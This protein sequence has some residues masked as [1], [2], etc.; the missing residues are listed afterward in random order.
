MLQI[1]STELAELLLSGSFGLEKESLRIDG[2]GFLSHTPHP[3]AGNPNIVRDFCENQTEINTSV[4]PSAHAAVSEL[5]RH[6]RTIQRTL[7]ELTPGEYLWPFSNPPYI[8]NEQDIP[9]AQFAGAQSDK[10]TYRNYLS[11]RYGRYKMTL[12]GIHVNYS[13]HEEL[14]RRDFQRSGQSSYIDYQNNLYLTLAKRVAAYGW[15]LTAVT[16]ASPLLDSSY[17]EK[18]QFDG[19]VFQGLASV[20]CSELG[21]WNAFAPVFDYSS[22][23]AYVESIR[24]YVRR[25][26]LRAPS[27]LYYPVRLKPAGPY[28][29]DALEAGGVN[30]IE[31]RMFDLNPLT[32]VGIDERDVSFAQLLLCWLAATPDQP[33]NDRD[34]VQAVQN[35]KN[36]AHYDLKTVNLMLPDGR[37]YSVAHAARN[38]ITLMREFYCYSPA[39]VQQVLDFEEAKFID[40]ENRYAWQIRKA[41]SGGFVRKGLALARQQQEAESG[42]QAGSEALGAERKYRLT[43]E[44]PLEGEA[45]V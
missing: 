10:T 4:Q 5:E 12:S 8:R 20:R 42:A 45:N 43:V 24:D 19:D 30:H 39:E 3:F 32:P 17:V 21:Y 11:K 34:Q 28:R 14:L 27:E 33:F 9:V 6:T 25:G 38:V 23:A 35:F 2:E 40:G 41:F 37:A 22:L 15:I 7:A 1:D 13:F 16:A 29:L 26:W 36:A 44:V 31:L 18:E